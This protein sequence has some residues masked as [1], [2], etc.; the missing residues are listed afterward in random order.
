M[1]VNGESVTDLSDCIV[2]EI[3]I[4]VVVVAADEEEEEEVV[5]TNG[6]G[7]FCNWNCEEILLPSLLLV[8]YPIVR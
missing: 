3:G 6:G 4:A 8:W 2:V 1:N 7:G 5:G